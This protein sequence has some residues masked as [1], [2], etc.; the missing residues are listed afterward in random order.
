MKLYYSQHSQDQMKLRE[1]LEE[2]VYLTIASPD[3]KIDHT[4][5]PEMIYHFKKIGEA[6]NKILRVVLKKLVSNDEYLIVTCYFD[7]KMRYIL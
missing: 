4:F 3:F 7:K 1:I 5:N 2:W 6:N